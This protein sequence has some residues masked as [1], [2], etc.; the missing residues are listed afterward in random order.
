MRP[1]AVVYSKAGRDKGEPFI[2]LS[3]D[4]AYAYL[5]DG[6]SRPLD[7]PKKKKLKH[8]QPTNATME[9]IGYKIEH[10]LHLMDS[11]IKKAL[12][13]VKKP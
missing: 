1:G 13:L 3:C 5:T 7:K 4:G 12:Q 9:D 6:Q 10:N 11:D 8:I 2:V